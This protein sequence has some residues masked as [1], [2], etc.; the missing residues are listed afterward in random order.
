VRADRQ[1]LLTAL[2]GGGGVVFTVLIA[3]PL[4]GGLNAGAVFVQNHSAPPCL[5]A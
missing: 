1:M 4:P 3:H 2:H 5:A